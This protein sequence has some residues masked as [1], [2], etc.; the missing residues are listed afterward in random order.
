MPAS[1]AKSLSSLFR[2]AIKTKAKSKSKPSSS[3]SVFDDPTLKN[4]V[5]VLESPAAEAAM[6][7][8]I[9]EAEQSTELVEPEEDKE[10]PSPHESDSDFVL[11]SPNAEVEPGSDTGMVVYKYNSLLFGEKNTK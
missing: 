6:S 8:L 11:Y 3:A 5:S 1:K 10:N 7:R 2:Q 4:F 9:T